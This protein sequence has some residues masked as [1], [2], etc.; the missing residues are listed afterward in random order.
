MKPGDT[1]DEC[2]RE[3]ERRVNWLSAGVV[4]NGL[5]NI[6]VLALVLVRT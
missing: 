5:A 6:C 1:Y 4:V 3:L 2:L